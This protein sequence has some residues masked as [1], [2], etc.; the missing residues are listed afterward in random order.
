M[1]KEEI[2]T[3]IKE[4]AAELG[5][6]PSITELQKMKGVL[7]GTI[8]NRFGNY[9]TAL[10]ECGLERSGPGYETDMRSLFLDW[11]GVARKLGKIPS[12]G[13][14]E[15]R[16]KFSVQPLMRRYGTWGEV[17][18]GLAEYARANGMEEEWADVLEM[19][20]RRRSSVERTVRRLVRPEARVIE[21]QPV[22]GMPVMPSPMV[23]A[24][25]YEGGVLFLFGAV[26]E[27]L[28][29]AVLRIQPG[30]PD[31]EAMREVS[32]GR[33]QPVKIEF[34]LESRNYLAHGHPSSGCNMIVC[35]VHNWEA[36]PFEVIELSK[37]FAGLK[38]KGR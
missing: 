14:Y 27:E 8:Y 18:A 32:P 38:G 15:A 17:P 24:P 19:I 2:L 25:T 37:V 11:A 36:C 4:C 7:K 10:K 16:A 31:C 30:F 33:W 9:R 3:A 21:D 13:D 26:A 34:E 5:H 1:T 29:F 6:A 22:Y 23:F 12:M 35:W 28:G 20:A